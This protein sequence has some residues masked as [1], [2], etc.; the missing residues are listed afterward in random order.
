MAT[1]DTT[2]TTPADRPA[3]APVSATPRASARR[4]PRA[5]ARRA[6]RARRAA[7]ASTR[8]STTRAP[9]TRVGTSTAP[10]A[11]TPIAQAQQLA[12]RVVLIPLGAALEA[13]D[14]VAD[15]VDEIVAKYGSVGAVDR[16]LKRFE[17]RG[18]RARTRLE[19][20]V[21]KTR[22]R[23]EREARHRRT[24]LERE[25][26]SA[27]RGFDRQ[28]ER[29]DPVRN[30]VENVV[31]NGVSAGIKLVGDAQSRLARVA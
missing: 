9:R 27:R 14:R 22:T 2:V 24:R 6:T 16:Q 29:V 26:T 31:Q 13:R 25:A 15:T 19:R 4:A 10:V 5:R 28:R 7:T 8:R 11:V 23:L 30:R 21:R 20:E 18:G 12:E 17:R 3:A 1:N